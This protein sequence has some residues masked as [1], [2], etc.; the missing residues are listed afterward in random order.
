MNRQRANE[1]YNPSILCPLCNH[2]EGFDID[3]NG[4]DFREVRNRMID[5]LTTKHDDED[6]EDLLGWIGEYPEE[7]E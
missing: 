2:L 4:D 5:H 1:Y 3:Q 6:A 7:E